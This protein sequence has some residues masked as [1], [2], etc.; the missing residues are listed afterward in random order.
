MQDKLYDNIYPNYAKDARDLRGLKKT[1]KRFL[2]VHLIRPLIIE[3]YLYKNRVFKNKQ[4]RKFKGV[5]DMK[6]NI[7]CGS[8]GLDNWI[9]V[10]MFKFEKV[11]CV[12]D[13]RK[14]LPFENNSAKMIFTEH[15]LNTLTTPKKCLFSSKTVFVYLNPEA[16]SESLFPIFKNTWMLMFLMV[17]RK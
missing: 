1:L 2:P 4:I 11:N 8:S 13:C 7:G 5:R 3:Y 6:I 15:F 9:N 14:S 17:G 12:Y 16:L 10:D